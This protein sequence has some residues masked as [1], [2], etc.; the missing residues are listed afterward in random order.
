MK[1]LKQ[2]LGDPLQADADEVISL[3]AEFCGESDPARSMYELAAKAA[4]MYRLAGKDIPPHVAEALASTKKI[5]SGD[6]LPEKNADRIIDEVLQPMLGPSI[7]V[8]CAYHRRTTHTDADKKL[9]ET[10]S[11]EVKQDWNKDGKA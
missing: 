6:Q 3:F 1:A 5:L 2:F 10:L 9:L 11:E 4:R 8:S 7:E